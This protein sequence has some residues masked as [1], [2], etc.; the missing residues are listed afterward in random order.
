MLIVSAT[1]PDKKTN[2]EVMDS[3]E[4]GNVLL[5]FGA[6]QIK[7]SVTSPDGQKTVTYS[8]HV[9]RDKFMLPVTIPVEL[10]CLICL[11]PVHCPVSFKGD[12]V[13]RYF[14]ESCV[15]LV[16]R[17][18]KHH[19]LTG[20]LLPDDFVMKEEDIETRISDTSVKCMLGCGEEMKM[21]LLAGH[22][23]RSCQSTLTHVEKVDQVLLGEKSDLEL[24][25]SFRTTY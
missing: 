20:E 14:C 17:L 22:M 8:I 7:I 1:S 24:Y 15:Q 5:K 16:T 19:P 2:I 11:A 23:V 13:Q 25:V 12:T 18:N 9:Q 6:T 21:R 4:G 10:R 3:E